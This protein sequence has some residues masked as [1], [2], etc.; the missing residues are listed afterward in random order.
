[1]DLKLSYAQ[2]LF[3]SFLSFS[4][5]DLMVTDHET[6]NL[7]LSFEKNP[8]R[9]VPEENRKDM[10]DYMRYCSSM[11]HEMGIMHLPVRSH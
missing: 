1:M 3:E 10:E 5:G 8:E 11:N 9:R 2:K 6:D 4:I 7:V